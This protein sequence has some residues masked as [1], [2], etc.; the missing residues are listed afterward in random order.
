MTRSTAPSVDWVALKVERSRLLL[1]SPSDDAMA[2]T[3]AWAAETHSRAMH[4]EGQFVRAMAVK[5]RAG[6]GHGSL[7]ETKTIHQGWS[8]AWE[9]GKGALELE[10]VVELGEAEEGAAD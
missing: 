10:L 8:G 7:W 5:E 9:T 4:E 2:P 3:V 1:Q 6:L